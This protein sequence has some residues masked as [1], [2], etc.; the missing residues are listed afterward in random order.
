MSPTININAFSSPK[1]NQ[2]DSRIS[3]R[4]GDYARARS[5]E[6]N[7]CLDVAPESIGQVHKWPAK[8]PRQGT[9]APKAEIEDPLSSLISER[10]M[11]IDND[12][13]KLGVRVGWQS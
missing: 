11:D 1:M 4:T 6:N 3:L 7:P 5:A 10:L 8:K 2:R 13:E 9:H 12:I